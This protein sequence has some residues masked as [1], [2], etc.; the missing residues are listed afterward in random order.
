MSQWLSEL[1][2]IGFELFGRDSAG[3]MWGLVTVCIFV[4]FGLYGKL[5]SGF[6]G[7]GE[8]SFLALVPGL[9]LIGLAL[10]SV[11][12]FWSSDWLWQMAAVLAILFLAVFPLTALVEKTSYLSAGLV[13]IVCLLV[14]AA[15]LVIEKPIVDSIRRGIQKGSLIKEENDFFEEIEKK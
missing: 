8:K 5:S 6:T 10:V 12:L 15:V 2:E 1:Q 3:E 11:R 14:L 7:K 13:W 9:L 4:F